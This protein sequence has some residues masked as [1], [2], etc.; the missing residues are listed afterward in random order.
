MKYKIGDLIVE[1]FSCPKPGPRQKKKPKRIPRVKSGERAA[2][3]RECDVAWSRAVKRRDGYQCRILNADG[4]RCKV[5]GIHAHHVFR[6]AYHATRWLLN[7]GLSVCQYHH[8]CP[9]LKKQ[10]LRV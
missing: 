7:N 2:L 1:V 10:C 9:D 8:G 6:R 3:E 4:N 5:L